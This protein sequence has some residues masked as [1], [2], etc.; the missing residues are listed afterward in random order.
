[1]Q[2]LNLYEFAELF[3]MIVEIC[4]PYITLIFGA[5]LAFVVIRHFKVL[6]LSFVR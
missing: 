3:H 6:L 5:M 2:P 4:T 1:M